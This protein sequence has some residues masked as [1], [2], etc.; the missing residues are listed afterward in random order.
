MVSVMPWSSPRTAWWKQTTSSRI[1]V[2]TPETPHEAK[3]QVDGVAEKYVEP[4]V[5]MRLDG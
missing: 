5:C 3:R 1:A 4:Y 2:A